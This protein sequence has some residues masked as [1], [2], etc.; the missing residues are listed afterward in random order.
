MRYSS[1]KHNEK[2]LLRKQTNPKKELHCIQSPIIKNV[3]LRGGA[4]SGDLLELGTVDTIHVCTALCCDRPRC[5]L[6]M[7]IDNTCIG[8]ACYSEE[9][10]QPIAARPTHNNPQLSY[11]RRRVLRSAAES[12]KGIVLSL[13]C[14]YSCLIG[15]R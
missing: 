9:L 7:L 2:P 8:V 11:I 14:N 3:T 6:A 5:D 13:L 4:R 1:I 12:R 10:W 15:S